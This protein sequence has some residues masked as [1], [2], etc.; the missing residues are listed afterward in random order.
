MNSKPFAIS[1][2]SEGWV[3]GTPMPRNDSVASS[4]IACARS[5]VA[6]TMSG[7]M[8]LGSRCRNTMR[9]QPSARQRAASMYSL[10]RSTSAA[11]R[12]VRAK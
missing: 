7:G 1:M 4:A 2:P 11:A 6:I 5:I 9:G 3:T 10:L 12:A 8:Q